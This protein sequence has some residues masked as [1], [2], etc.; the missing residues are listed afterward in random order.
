MEPIIK[1]IL[2]NDTYKFTMQQGVLELFP[3]SNAEYRFKNRGKQRF[4]LPFLRELKKQIQ[5]MSNLCLSENEYFWIKNNIPFLKPLYL[6]YLKNYRY[7]PEE[8]VASLDKDNN[9]EIAIIGKWHSAIFWEVPLMAIISEL[10]FTIIDTS[11]KSDDAEISKN[12]KNKS[13]ELFINECFFAEFG[14]RRRRSFFVQD[15]VINAFCEYKKESNQKFFVGTSNVYFAMKYGTKIVGTYAHEWTMG[16]SVLEGLRNSN[17]YA[18][19]NWKRVYCSNLGI[20]LTDTYGL[21]TFLKNF[22]L[23]FS[24]VYDGVRHDSGCPFNFTDKIIEHYKK[25]NIDPM[26]KTIVFSDGLNTELVIQIKKYC[27]NRIK[28][29][30]GIGTHFTNDFKN[31]P[32]LN[33]VIKLW[34]INGIPVVKLPDTEGKTFGDE[35]AIK[36][37]QWTFYK[38]T[39]D[40]RWDKKCPICESNNVI[41]SKIDIEY[42][43]E[44][45]RVF[46][47]D[48]KKVFSIK[49]VEVINK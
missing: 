24:K 30:F 3:N 47:D 33:M 22:T 13:K 1:S 9:L 10:Y 2:D 48:C 17:Y 46:C 42:N 38:K 21:D 20:A 16:N 37:A 29:S 6:E 32:A 31:S 40:N 39:L 41:M 28:C 45:V 8:V 26:S 34:S 19:Q 23:E 7:K 35:D 18:M 11:W 36:V 15:R 43:R 14:T 44:I 4:S 49:N 25:L 5:K 27:E 12:A